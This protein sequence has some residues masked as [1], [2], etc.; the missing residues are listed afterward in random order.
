MRRLNEIR[1]TNGN[2]IKEQDSVHRYEFKAEARMV[3]NAPQSNDSRLKII[4]RL[5]MSNFIQKT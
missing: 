3:A 5:E 1:E 2:K 4:L